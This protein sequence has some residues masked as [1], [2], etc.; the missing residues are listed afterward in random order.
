MYISFEFN[1]LQASAIFFVP[2]AFVSQAVSLS[3]S[4]ASTF[5]IA[6]A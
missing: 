2:M 6:A 4:Q 3:I 5:V 1:F